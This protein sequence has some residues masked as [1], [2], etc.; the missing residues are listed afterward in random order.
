MTLVSD[1]LAR[2]P[3][4]KGKLGRWQDEIIELRQAGASLSTICRFLAEQG[5]VAHSGEVHRFLNRCGRQELINHGA[6]KPSNLMQPYSSPPAELPKFDW[7]PKKTSTP[8]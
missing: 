7:P 6:R 2:H 4:R 8:W 1:F 3:T 5:V